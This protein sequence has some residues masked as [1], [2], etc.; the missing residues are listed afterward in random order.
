MAKIISILNHKGG[1]GK[2]TT[3]I[4]LGAGLA[5]LGYRVLLIDLDGQE[6]L[7]YAFRQSGNDTH[8]VYQA[9]RG[10]LDALP[11]VTISERLHLVPSHLDLGVVDLELASEPGRE[12]ILSLLLAPHK[13]QYDYI[14][15]DCPPSLGLLTI[16]ALTASQ[17]III[18]VEAEPFAYKGMRKLQEII[19][20]VQKRINPDLHVLGVLITRYDGR[21]NLHQ[22]LK[23][24]LT[25]D[26]NVFD[27]LIRSNISLSEAH[28]QQ[29]DI[30]TH[31][32]K[33]N[34]AADYIEFSKEVA[35]K[36][37]KK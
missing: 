15:I 11:I 8:N 35:E 32:P 4:N 17:E 21:K 30:F 22:V 5:Q 36:T 16:N 31:A 1:V 13:D 3:S 33:S 28:I 27:T 14:L 10:N 25:Q 24:A 2:T 20:K 34:G 6:N 9:M 18:P 23:N 12:T 37:L 29:C 19:G 26:I 7:S